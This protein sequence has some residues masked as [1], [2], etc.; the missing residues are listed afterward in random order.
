MSYVPL[1]GGPLRDQRLFQ[2]LIPAIGKLNFRR[3]NF[4]PLDATY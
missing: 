3:I 4:P 1:N 2:L